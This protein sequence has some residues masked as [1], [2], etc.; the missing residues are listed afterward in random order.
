[1]F[2]DG[3]AHGTIDIDNTLFHEFLELSKSSRLL[4]WIFPFAQACCPPAVPCIFCSHSY[5]LHDV[6]YE[7]KNLP[8]CA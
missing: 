2:L 3:G 7:Q 5:K 1:M 6:E 8:V 4:E